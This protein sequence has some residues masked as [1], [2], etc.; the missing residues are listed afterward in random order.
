MASELKEPRKLQLCLLGFPAAFCWL[1][2]VTWDKKHPVWE[3]ERQ[4]IG[5]Q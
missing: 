2:G 1:S 4:D 5:D 3:S